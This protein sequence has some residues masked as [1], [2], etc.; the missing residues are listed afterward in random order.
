MRYGVV[1]GLAVLSLTFLGVNFVSGLAGNAML[2]TQPAAPETATVTPGGNGSQS[3]SL[4]PGPDR[5]PTPT[6]TPS[7]TP[8]P[9]A[10]LSPTPTA[11]PTATPTPTPTPTATTTPS[12][13]PT[14]DAFPKAEFWQECDSRT[15]V[16]VHYRIEVLGTQKVTLQYGSD[17]WESNF[18]ETMKISGSETFQ[19]SMSTRGG[20]WIE[21][22]SG[23]KVKGEPFARYTIGENACRNYSKSE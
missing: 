2:D 6:A 12:P 19:R 7:P 9:T 15:S 10:T 16:I 22:Y 23:K 21:L 14:P 11:T 18:P 1:F 5:S 13:T 8:T 17:T 3:A 4:T 20:R